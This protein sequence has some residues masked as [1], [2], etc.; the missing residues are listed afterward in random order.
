MGTALAKP[1]E[2]VRKMAPIPAARLKSCKA[3]DEISPRGD[4]S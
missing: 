3:D 2:A 1:A 4:G